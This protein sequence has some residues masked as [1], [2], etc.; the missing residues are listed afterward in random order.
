LLLGGGGYLGYLYSVDQDAFAE[1]SAFLP[2]I[3]QNRVE[4]RLASVT[5][6][7]GRS[8]D[9]VVVASG[10]LES[11]RQARIGARAAGRIDAILFEEGDKVEKGTLL[12][13]LDHKDMDAA[14]AAA[15]ASVARAKAGL[16]EQ[17]VVID[18]SRSEMDRAQKLRSSRS[19]SD[20]EYDQARY[21]Y[22]AAVARHES[23]Q[24]EI[25][26]AEAQRNQSEQLREN[27]FIR[28]PFNGT[29]ISKDAEEGESIQPGGMGG[30]SGRGSVAT[31]ADLEH[32]EIEVDV[33]ED[34]ISRVS[35]G[36]EADIAMDSVQN[37]KYHGAVRKIIPMGDRARATIKVKVHIS[38]ADERLFPEMSGTVYFLPT[39]TDLESSDEPR[40]FCP[41]SAIDSDD[42]G[43]QF[44][45]VADSK[46]RAQKIAVKAG[47]A[48]D[49]RTEIIGGLTGKER[50]VVNPEELH[51]GAPLLIAE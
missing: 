31:I 1:G 21:A 38:D 44:V 42:Q 48:R 51:E 33:Q 32:L 28:A 16:A 20:S 49:G 6:Q 27:M 43:N 24:S 7:E 14:L 2:E 37:K 35:E 10:Y 39:E 34:F 17:Q 12:A 26:L 4:V 18:Q 19:V 8:A 47:G 22:R 5:V 13:E 30:T 29:V 25:V 9:A 45:W 3:M 50:V 23:M 40:M 46:K 36:Q 15:S 41:T 11:R